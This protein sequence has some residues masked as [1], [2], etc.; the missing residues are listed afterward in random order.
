MTRSMLQKRLAEKDSRVVIDWSEENLDAGGAVQ[1][2]VSWVKGYPRSQDVHIY[3]SAAR[4]EALNLRLLQR[5]LQSIGC[6][7]IARVIPS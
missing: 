7:V 5:T 6:T 3:L 1:N 4:R 2:L